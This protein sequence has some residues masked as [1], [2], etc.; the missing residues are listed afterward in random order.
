VAGEIE[1]LGQEEL[2]TLDAED[3]AGVR[4]GDKNDQPPLDPETERI[5]AAAAR[6]G[7]H[8]FAQNL[9]SNCRKSCVFRGLRPSTFGGRRMLLPDTSSRGGTAATASALTWPTVWL[10]APVMT[11]PLIQGCSRSKTTY[12]LL[13]PH[14]CLKQCELIVWP[15]TTTEP[16]PYWQCCGCRKRRSCLEPVT[17]IGTVALCSLTAAR[18]TRL[19]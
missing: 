2:A 4:P 1:L 17:W 11:W 13:S 10:P 12:G 19:N 6:V 5:R 9:L 16:R 8:V 7:Q 3:L 14:H 15:D 18:S